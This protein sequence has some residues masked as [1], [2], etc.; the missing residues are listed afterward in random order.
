M[1]LKSLINI[2]FMDMFIIYI[3]LGNELFIYFVTS[4]ILTKKIF[5]NKFFF[6]PITFFSKTKKLKQT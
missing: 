2:S 5:A 4:H 1:P 3:S 6:P